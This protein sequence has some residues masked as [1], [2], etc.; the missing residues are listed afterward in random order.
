M[1]GEA[2]PP[3]MEVPQL[4]K[5][6]DR[7]HHGNQTNA[8]TTRSCLQAGLTWNG[9][10]ASAPG[11]AGVRSARAHSGKSPCSPF[12]CTSPAYSEIRHASEDGGVQ[13]SKSTRT[14]R[15]RHGIMER[16]LASMLPASKPTENVARANFNRDIS[17]TFHC[18]LTLARV[19]GYAAFLGPLPGSTST[20]VR[21]SWGG[22]AQ[23]SP[24]H[25][26]AQSLASNAPLLLNVGA[27]LRRYAGRAPL[28]DDCV[29]RQIEGARHGGNTISEINCLVKCAF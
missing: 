29:A 24:I 1:G 6:K 12:V 9:T 15:R 27:M 28:V 2:L 23:H 19:E 3:R 10:R 17:H 4:T 7:P 16:A 26:G 14:R 22:F 18:W 5:P 11:N 21:S 8:R 25:I 20:C 13:G